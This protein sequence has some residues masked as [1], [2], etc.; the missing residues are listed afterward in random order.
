MT[1]EGWFVRLRSPN[2]TP[3]D[4]LAFNRWYASPL[5]AKTY[6]DLVALWDKTGL[7]ADRPATRARRAQILAQANK[8]QA[9]RYT[10]WAA[11]AAA[12]VV[13]VSVSLFNWKGTIV[14]TGVGEQKTVTLQDGSSVVLDTASAVRIKFTSKTRAIVLEEG[15]AFFE[16]AH[17][18]DHPFT[19]TAGD[20]RVTAIGTAF[21]VRRYKDAVTVTLASG[22]VAV[23]SNKPGEG[24]ERIFPQE[25]TEMLTPNQQVSYSSD[26]LQAIHSV[27]SSANLSWARGDIVFR[28]TPLADAVAEINR[29]TE[30]KLQFADPTLGQLQINGV[31]HIS[32][33][34]TF[35]LALDT[36]FGVKVSG[37]GDGNVRI[38]TRKK[39]AP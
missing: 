29:Y 7:V 31:F 10:G 33:I 22:V 4:I 32:D 24:V 27:D 15:Q 34:D 23:T 37:A 39:N 6:D 20:G 12:A 36:A 25:K 14:R 28:R 2:C 18:S 26:G 3:T 16:V 30:T 19:V 8:R 21:A 35:L 1:A 13:L 17:Q 11:A 5:A 9:F 38:L